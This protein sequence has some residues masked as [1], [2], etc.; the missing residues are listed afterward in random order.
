[1]SMRT[2]NM[3]IG[4]PTMLDQT[5]L[6]TRAD[7]YYGFADGMHTVAFYLK[8]FKGR[9]IIEASL[10][11]NPAESDWF[12]IG[13]GGGTTYFSVDSVSTKV[14]TFNIVGNFVYLRAKVL[15]SYLNETVDRLGACERVVLSL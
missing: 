13:L 15:R 2:T 12:P 10:S 8:N 14:E 9:L 5:G 1:M 4:N 3:L 7:G 11:D 6:A